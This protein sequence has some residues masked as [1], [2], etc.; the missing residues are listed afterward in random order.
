MLITVGKF[1][2]A[3]LYKRLIGEK[4]VVRV[5]KGGEQI[6][7]G[8]NDRIR[9]MTFELPDK[10]VIDWAYWQHVEDALNDGLSV[11]SRYASVSFDGIT[12]YWKKDLVSSFNK[13]F[14]LMATWDGRNTLNFGEDGPYR[15]TVQVGDEVEVKVVV[16]GKAARTA[17]AGWTY[18][19]L[20]LLPGTRFYSWYSK[21]AKKEPAGMILDVYG[22]PS[23]DRFLR[24]AGNQ[25][26]HWRGEV[27]Y[28][29]PPQGLGNAGWNECWGSYAWR[30]GDAGFN[31]CVQQYLG[32]WQNSTPHYPGFSRVIKLKVVDIV[33]ND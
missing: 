30:A 8:D 9:R 19:A 24:A 20:P 15:G 27:Y 2:R 10:T 16:P 11:G 3:H 5:M 25:A 4:N 23:G 14:G 32:G 18:Y 22:S 7:P 6:W 26:G 13:R 1:K 31:V 12:W 29:S 33:Y 21:G 17:W 28:W